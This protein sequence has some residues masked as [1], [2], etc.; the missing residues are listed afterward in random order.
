MSSFYSPN[1]RN[2]LRIGMGAFGAGLCSAPTFAL[3]GRED[4]RKLIFVILR[5]AMDGLAALPPVGDSNYA[6]LRGALAYQP[7]DGAIALDSTFSLAPGFAGL[8][9]MWDAGE[10]AFMPASGTPYRER[11][12]FEGQ[13]VL[14]TG[15][16]G[17]VP[18]SD[19]WLN[20]A[21]AGLGEAKA[22]R[23]LAV[24]TI[25]PL[26]L[27]GRLPVSNWAPVGQNLPDQDFMD[28]LARLYKND[29]NLTDSLTRGRAVHLLAD[30][31]EMQQAAMPG[32]NPMIG[33]KDAKP[34]RRVRA[35]N[36]DQTARVSADLITASGGPQVTVFDIGGFDTHA[37]QGTAGGRLAP[38]L[39]D[40]ANGL[41]G[42]KERLG[43]V[44]A[45]TV[46]I[47][48][49]EFGRTVR[50]NGTNGTDHGTG[51]TAILAGGA[52]KGGRIIGDWPGLGPSGLYEDRDLRP[53][54]D[55]RGLF[56]AALIDHL[57][58]DPVRINRLIFPDSAGAQPMADLFKV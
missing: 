42:L 4:D 32:S 44:W 19:G 37:D 13:A 40:L 56:K 28:R 53:V 41:V 24:A 3:A 49:S 36:F 27:S 54:N 7:A 11:S 39:I 55:L 46:V 14:E 57:G 1:R 29:P 31:A 38:R 5:G 43:P 30:G 15:A 25:V 34:V 58:L 50:I 26:I 8:K 10:L 48:A 12:H 51:G 45:K 9:P 20:R 33:T 35:S 17:L 52:V 6:A 16:P 47:C 21:L 23:A 2:V 18:L 22:D